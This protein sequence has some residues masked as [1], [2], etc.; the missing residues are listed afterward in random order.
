MKKI[1]LTINLISVICMILCACQPKLPEETTSS[2]GISILNNVSSILPG[3]TIQLECDVKDNATVSFSTTNENIL[4]VDSNGMVTA[5]APGTATVVAS[6]G[7]YEKAYLTITVETDVML[8]KLSLQMESELVELLPKMKY[9]PVVKITKGENE[10]GNAD[11]Q[12]TSSNESVATVSGG[13]V[14]AI[15]PGESL[16]KVTVTADGETE[17]AFCKIVV[18]EHYRICIEEQLIQTP[19][20]KEFTITPKIYDADGNPQM[21]ASDDLEY[22]TSN[23]LAIAVEK[24]RF[25]VIGTGTASAGVRYKGNVASIPVEIFSVTA[26]FFETTAVDFYGEV[27]GS[28]FSGIVL[29]SSA[30]QPF[31]HFSDSGISRIQEY[32]RENDFATLRIHTYAI[33]KN[34]S[35][36]INGRYIG[37]QTWITTDVPISEITDGFWFQ[38]ESEGTTEVYMWFELRS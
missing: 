4:C 9:Q 29:N 8:P 18:H 21:V 25:K 23:P 22:F 34:N 30:Y 17:T 2:V 7:E 1:I 3:E 24:G 36:R 12:W 32:A 16:I 6:I 27:S 31:F 14:E 37:T 11:V 5:C 13:I 10:V 35:F 28:I 26:D 15:A 19:I 20:G 33:L 38:S